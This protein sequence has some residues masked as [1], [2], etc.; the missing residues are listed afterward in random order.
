L[1]QA[2][3]ASDL[4]VQE[5]DTAVT[6]A[7]RTSPLLTGIS[8]E[9]VMYF[10]PPKGW[11]REVTLLNDAASR[12]FVPAKGGEAYPAG[13]EIL[14]APGAVVALTNMGTTV[15]LDGMNWDRD[16]DNTVRGCRYATALLAG[17]GAAFVEPSGRVV[18]PLPLGYF[19][20]VGDSPYSAV[21]GQEIVLRS[22]GTVEAEFECAAEGGYEIVLGGS[23]TPAGGEYAKVSV[24]VDGSEV[25]VVEMETS[26]RWSAG[27]VRLNRG[28]HR[29]AV[30]FINDALI[31]GED[32][33]VFLNSVELSPI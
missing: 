27:T 7:A 9:D 16:G 5:K 29:L 17:L 11:T 26:G 30:K 19:K 18:T 10:S 23:S 32:R 8:R 6:L 12:V 14:I 22:A 3:G 13:A 31:G 25:A 4:E 33:N 1:R 2:L 20:L 28:R 21:S 24:R 15:V